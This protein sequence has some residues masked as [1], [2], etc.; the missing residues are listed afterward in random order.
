[1]SKT[2]KYKHCSPS[3]KHIGLVYLKTNERINI[4][5][6]RDRDIKD[7]VDLCHFVN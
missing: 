5:A 2:Y 1:M 3:N 7:P 6:G 4:D